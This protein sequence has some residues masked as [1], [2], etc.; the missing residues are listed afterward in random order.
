MNRAT[1]V[2]L[3]SFSLKNQTST[4]IHLD[5]YSPSSQKNFSRKYNGA[6]RIITMNMD[7]CCPDFSATFS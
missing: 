6:A 1:P 4:F 5:R 3:S 7:S 2:A